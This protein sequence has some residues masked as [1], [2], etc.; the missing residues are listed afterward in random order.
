[1]CG[2]A[3]YMIGLLL[4]SLTGAV[5]CLGGCTRGRVVIPAHYIQ[6]DYKPLSPASVVFLLGNPPFGNEL[7]SFTDNV[8]HS[9]NIDI[10][11][12]DPIH[13]TIFIDLAPIS[14]S[15]DTV[16]AQGGS[17]IY[18][19]Q[20]NPSDFDKVTGMVVYSGDTVSGTFSGVGFAGTGSPLYDTISGTFSY[21]PPQK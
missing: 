12:S 16:F 18:S 3:N 2:A 4:F 1:M 6:P 10:V 14:Q 15:G 11:A 9:G 20:G 13:D 8:Y 21:V 17:V 5:I 7:L 19:E